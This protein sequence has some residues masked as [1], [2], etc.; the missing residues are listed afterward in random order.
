MAKEYFNW[1]ANEDVIVREQQA[2]AVY[3]NGQGDVVIRQSGH[4]YEDDVWIVLG[5]QHAPALA[6]AILEAACYSHQEIEVELDAVPALPAPRKDRTAAERQRRYRE[7]RNGHE[8]VT[9]ELPLRSDGRDV[10]V[11]RS[12]GERVPLG[13]DESHI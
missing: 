9:P 5:P 6:R 11:D 12:R 10:T 13:P 8:T 3:P 7:R 4:L 1:W 2:I